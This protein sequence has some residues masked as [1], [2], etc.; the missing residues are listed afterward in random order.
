MEITLT[1][2]AALHIREFLASEASSTYLRLGV[3]TTGCSG[4]MSVS[5]THLTL[6]TKA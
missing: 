3:K 6:P 4:Y 2:R 1:E 5:Y